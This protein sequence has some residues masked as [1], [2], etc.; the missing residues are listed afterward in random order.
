MN[1]PSQDK[2]AFPRLVQDTEILNAQAP[3][4][5]DL[6]F[7]NHLKFKVLKYIYFLG[8]NTLGQWESNL[9]LNYYQV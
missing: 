8:I 9:I 7:F 1:F 4:I 6:F 2:K 3:M 5:N